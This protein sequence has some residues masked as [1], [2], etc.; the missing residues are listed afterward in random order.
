MSKVKEY[1][2]ISDQWFVETDT[3]FKSVTPVCHL[4]KYLLIVLVV[5]KKYCDACFVLLM[6]EHKL[7]ANAMLRILAE[8]RFKFEWCLTS[9]ET[10]KEKAEQEINKRFRR[11][12]Y[13]SLHEQRNGL[14]KVKIALE[15]TGELREIQQ[16]IEGKGEELKKGAEN[17]EEKYGEKIKQMPQILQLLNE[18]Q[19]GLFSPSDAH[20]RYVSEYLFYNNSIH[21]DWRS[22]GDL[23]SKEGEEIVIQSDSSDNLEDLAKRCLS[24]SFAFNYI[25]R[26]VKDWDVDGMKE[27]FTSLK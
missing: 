27:E 18:D 13:T 14:E 19:D 21:L 6:N 8:L 4:D 12:A 16:M 26:T 2:G 3:L 5:S 1:H 23:C 25:V 17:Y 11:W 20:R 15:G 10:E 24:Q 22:M 9:G 7:P